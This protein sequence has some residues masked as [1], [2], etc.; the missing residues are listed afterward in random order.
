MGICTPSLSAS[1]ANAVEIERMGAASA[2]LQLASQ[3]GQVAGI[4]LME[5]VQVAGER[6]RGL[7]GSFSSAY[8]VAGVVAALGVL[9]SAFVRRAVRHDTPT[10]APEPMI[11]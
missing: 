7:V 10:L 4:Q 5:T 11:G 6:S 2:A 9:A 1:V 3:V 8:L